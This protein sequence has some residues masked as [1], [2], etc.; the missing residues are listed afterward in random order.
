MSFAKLLQRLLILRR[1][2]HRANRLG[3][4]VEQTGQRVIGNPTSNILPF[5]QS[6]EVT[7]RPKTPKDVRGHALQETEESQYCSY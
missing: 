6:V 3:G 4:L 5:A 1:N 2:D 7:L